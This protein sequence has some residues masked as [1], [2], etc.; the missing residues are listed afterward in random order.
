MRSYSVEP[1]IE[2]EVA[3]QDGLRPASAACSPS[4]QPAVG[5]RMATAPGTALGR[6]RGMDVQQRLDLRQP[7]WPAPSD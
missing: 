6:A 5:S 7:R 1:S 3:E 2:V 4:V